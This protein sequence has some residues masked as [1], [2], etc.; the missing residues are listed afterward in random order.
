MPG[1]D[2]FMRIRLNLACLLLASGLAPTLAAA[3]LCPPQPLAAD[4]NR[5]T[6]TFPATTTQLSLI[7][8]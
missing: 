4:P 1:I 2:V 3:Q 5:P 7:H 6:F 8:I